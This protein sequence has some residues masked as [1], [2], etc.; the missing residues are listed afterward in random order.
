M[1][2]NLIKVS[3]FIKK[4]GKMILP[5]SIYVKIL[6]FLGLIM[7]S[8]AVMQPVQYALSQEMIKIR[9]ELIEK[10][11][12]LTGTTV[13][14]SSMR[15]S[16][17]GSFNINNL[18]FSMGEDKPFFTISRIKIRF[19]IRELLLRKKTFVYAIQIDRPELNMDT[20]KDAEIFELINSKI[21]DIKNSDY[22]F[23]F[24]KIT[25]F[26]PQKA[27]YQ[28]SHLNINLKDIQTEY[29]IN[30][31]NLNIKEK[32]GEIILFGRFYAELKKS[33]IFDRTIYLSADTG[34]NGVCSSD[35]KNG[36]AELS[37]YYA[38]CSEQGRTE[39]KAAFLNPQSNSGTSERRLFNL[40][41]FKTTV[42]FSD[43]LLKVEPYKKDAGNNYYFNYNTGTGSIQA[44]LNLED[45]E[46]RNYIN[47]SEYLKNISD[48]FSLQI[49]GSSSFNYQNGD[50]NYYA[51]IKSSNK[52][53]SFD[54]NGN[55]KEIIINEFFV[56][57]ENQANKLFYGSLGLSGNLQFDPFKSQGIV[58]FDQFS[59]TGKEY[60]NAVFNISGNER[61]ILVSSDKLVIAQT[62][63]KELS[64]G[65][66]PGEKETEIN[67]SGFFN[68]SGSVYLDAVFSSNPQEIEAT[69]TIDSLSL[70]D[71]SE[72]L[73]PF[74]DYLN[75]PAITR[76]RLKNSTINTD[77]FFSTDFNNIMYSAPNIVFSSENINGLFS[78]YGTDRQITLS[79][80]I[81]Y[82]NENEFI[83]SSNLNFS[84]PMDLSFTLNAN[85]QDITWN[86]EG[87]IL[88]RTTVIVRDASGFHGYANI[89][90]N[91]ALSGY[92][93]GINYPILVN[94]Q[95][96][97]L[98]FYLS[99]RYDSFDFWHL[100]VD[101][102]AARRSNDES[103]FL[104]ISGLADQYGASFREI[105]YIDAAGT[106]LGSVDLSW[107]V[108]FSYL[109]FIV[110]ITDRRDTGEFYYSRGMLKDNSINI[111]VSVSDMRINRFFR[112]THPVLL[113][114]D[115][116]VSWNSI[117][118]F[119]GRINLSSLN[120]RIDDNNIYGSV[121][122]MLSNEEL[123]VNDL[124]FDFAGLKTS[125]SELKFN[126]SDGFIV[127]KADIQ[128]VVLERKI[129]GDIEINADFAK[130]N[131]WLELNK[132]LR[133]FNG[134]L[135]VDN[136]TYGN[137]SDEEFKLEFSGNEGAFSVKGGKNDMIRF[138]MD[139]DGIFFAGLSAPMP[140]H[141]NLAGT[142]KNGIINSQNNYFFIDMASL[143]GIFSTQNEFL[144]TGGFI[145]GKSDLTGPFWNPE[146]HG[147]ARATSMRFQVPNFIKEEILMAPI[148][149]LAEGYEMIFDSV[150]FVSGNGGGKVNG[151]FSFE[152]WSP[153]NIGLDVTIPREAPVPYNINVFGFLANG[154]A[155][156]NLNM[157]IDTNN[158]MMEMK[159]DIFTNEA[160]LSLNMDDIFANMENERDTEITFNTIVELKVTAG[161]MVEFVWPTGNPMLRATPEMGS[162][163]LIK[164]DTIAG[165]YSL[166]SNVKIRSGELYY[167]ERSFFIRQ[168]SMV[169]KENENQFDPRISARAEI[170][171]RSETGPVTISMIIENQPLFRFEPRFEASPSLTQLEIYSILGQNFDSIRGEEN[172]EMATRFLLTSGTDL[173][174]QLIAGSEALSQFVF[175]RQIERQVRNFMRLDMFS[176]RTHFIQN[177]VATGV[178][179]LGLTA[180]QNPID[181]SNRLGNYFD[182]TTVF[183]GKYIG[184]DMFFQ[185]MLPLKYDE[186][187]DAFGGLKLEPDIG[188]ELQS[189]VMNIRWDIFPNLENW[190]MNDNSITLSWSKSF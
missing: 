66:S 146:F 122:V 48:I 133:N 47:L 29:K 130:V 101:Y 69:V 21:N 84:N 42:S 90:N 11:E 166:N 86:I 73:R 149:V 128:G 143:F 100:D 94:S 15:P 6:V 54:V 110:N 2:Y 20:V 23:D 33:G 92:I 13:R 115:A 134:K 178:T 32:D 177:A 77:I 155:S 142:F 68:E 37:F 144:I 93:E 114:A 9:T 131:S 127:S 61:D 152:N 75:I 137:I 1:C 55:E 46:P 99:L 141:G 103:D 181:R 169:F 106:L 50:M 78:V 163:I 145:T 43:N 151:W 120:S 121:N 148:D 70:F 17:F 4:D 185:L 126:I 14:Y 60:F 5:G 26:L 109:E 67:A 119:N 79:E 172:T 135:S 160:D 76:G 53:L 74:S 125:L 44:G 190:R 36:G 85:Y 173:V 140:I 158:L 154:I 108:N 136:F 104:R 165:Q 8:A 98:N 147:T 157:T 88:D 58:Y 159:G 138:E 167:F 91:G 129:K 16:F 30:N 162:V 175:Y 176:V 180:G 156:G 116:S 188:I 83:F 186:N 123:L 3:I 153:A 62:V 40:L 65:F 96:V 132:I 112:N 25:E 27:D 118:S 71:I 19:S 168:G 184:Q 49:T 80:G 97:L 183:I 24:Q 150:S 56:S 59:L 87:Q 117:D 182:N 31:M 22:T 63:I 139:S 18:S 7:L 81:I 89:T 10:L 57:L 28:I 52:E 51:D 45:F 171:D 39:K 187:R 38:T 82:Q 189:P 12:D 64:I 72:I 111:D 179:G 170:R 41:P 35:M 174:M 107:D 105:S 164:S 34:I 113:S 161:S 124:K 102:I 95:T